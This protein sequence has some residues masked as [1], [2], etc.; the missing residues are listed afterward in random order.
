V[1]ERIIA[2][3]EELGLETAE[4]IQDA[5][6]L[7]LQIGPPP[8]A[9][10]QPGGHPGVGAPPAAPP[11]GTAAEPP[12]SAE[13]EEPGQG[14]GAAMGGEPGTGEPGTG[15]PQPLYLD[16]RTSGPVPGG[17]AAEEAGAVSVR[18]A[19]APALPESLRIGRSLRPLRRR[20]PVPF[21]EELD[22]EATAQQIA[23]SRFWLPVLRPG[24][25]RWLD[26]AMV[27]DGS[28]SMVIWRRTVASLHRL[29]ERQ[30]AFRDSRG[31]VLAGDGG[32]DRGVRVRP[33][34]ERA[35]REGH[36]RDAGELVD[37]T[38]RRLVMIVTDGVAPRWRSQAMR[39][40]VARW[41]LAGP[42]VIVQLLPERLW[43][44]VA[45]TSEP[46]RIRAPFPGCPSAALTVRGAARY[47]EDEEAQGRRKRRFHV[48]VVEL[49]PQ[50]LANWSA[51][52][53]GTGPT[54]VPGAVSY[55][56]QPD[57]ADA[58]EAAER[59]REEPGSPL[60]RVERFLASA[61]PGARMLAGHL[62]VVPLTVPVMHLVREVT[63][64][65]AGLDHL[66]EVF[67]SGLIERRP[68]PPDAPAG[69][70]ETEYD[71]V[72]GVRE[73]LLEGVSRTDAYL[74]LREVGA[75]IEQH[76]PE[77]SGLLAL[78]ADPA[79][80]RQVQVSER[81]RSFAL[82]AAPVLRR[83]GGLYE[84]A[85]EAFPPPGATGSTP[86]VA[87]RP[88][89]AVP[90]HPPAPEGTTRIGLL[91]APGSG[92]TTFLAALEVASFD[93]GWFIYGSDINA[94]DFLK[95]S[96]L[97]LYERREFPAATLASSSLSW[98][99]IGGRGAAGGA[100]RPRRA[101]EADRAVRFTLEVQD[102]P[103]GYFRGDSPPAAW[104]D[105]ERIE[106]LDHL[107]TCQ[108]LV[109]LFDPVREL[110][111]G[112][113]FRYLGDTLDHLVKRVHQRTGSPDPR[114]PHHL[115]VCVTKFDDPRI[116]EPAVGE[117]W[118]TWD[119]DGT[120]L[121]GVRAERT[122]AFFAWLC[123]ER[124]G[125]S[126][127]II[128]KLIRQYFHHSRVAYFVSSSIGFRV[129]AGGA[130]SPDDYSNVEVGPGGRP[131][132]R[133]DVRPINVLEPFIWLERSIRRAAG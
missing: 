129:G 110:Q 46:A 93:V 75:Y 101:R 89:A 21:L 55:F 92:K 114:L 122:E 2:A 4:D 85:A 38:G 8:D 60:A 23:E 77:T 27:V 69:G 48:P 61:S 87:A 32:P 18:V 67:L 57:P 28:E 10:G 121:P 51:L 131:R 45:L 9:A 22:E 58:E 84:Q 111:A 14:S 90:A 120:G 47:E 63:Q 56:D 26:L 54:W 102:L 118:I 7:A 19:S 40:T 34:P 5:L 44:R 53:A 12:H 79:G 64:E 20:I 126:A 17:Q 128:R 125:G 76:D 81:S 59:A 94:N 33:W 80:R 49:S 113:S 31:W 83:L 30:G 72:P 88:A 68:P 107:A 108:G 29:L 112:D 1:I 109:Y 115:A 65:G 70:E 66:A 119:T 3:L 74:V 103:G 100:P 6:W 98:E 71:F 97:R 86:L 104:Q 105:P 41:S 124:A 127:R 130:V 73:L 96:Y 11:R 117:G 24:L 82:V 99:V 50:W 123:D 35:T 13:P 133:G 132:L 16:R 106:M 62:A 116:F 91:G 36:L 43:G 42:V 39:D 78:F 52:V 95:D 25:S 15:E 37:P